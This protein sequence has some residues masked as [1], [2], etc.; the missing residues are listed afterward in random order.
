MSDPVNTG[1]THPSP[2]HRLNDG[3]A[4]GLLIAYLVLR[5]IA[6]RV[7][8]AYL[9]RLLDDA[10]WAIPLLN[11]STLTLVAAGTGVR[12]DGGAIVATA[13][14]SIFQ[15]LITG[16][17]LYWAGLRFGP[18]LAERASREGSLWAGIWNPK[19]VQ[20]A[21]R[22][23]DRRGVYAV[24]IARG[25]VEWMLTPVLLVAGSTKMRIG[26]FA[27]SF[28]AGSVAFAGIML[29]LGGRAGD[30]WPW[31]PDKIKAFGDWS[32]RIVLGLL[33]LTLIAVLLSRR[34]EAKDPGA[35]D[36]DATTTPSQ[37]PSESPSTD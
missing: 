9:P 14:T 25:A 19:H 1:E 22:W 11:N 32:L 26:K 13:A 35:R 17:F 3:V 4:V 24:F 2:R 36:Q 18:W 34:Q 27:A 16:A 33:V 5:T 28:G 37:E 21:S 10:P 8:L 6:N 29:W 30:A 15:S 20:R 12:G 7:G 23:I 31:L